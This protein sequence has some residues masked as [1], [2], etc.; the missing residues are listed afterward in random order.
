MVIQTRYTMEEFIEFVHLPGNEDRL[1]ELING[2]ITEAA[3]RGTRFSET[4]H[5]ITFAVRLFCRDHDILDGGDVLP[6]FSIAVA[7][8]FR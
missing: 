5:I 4:E 6:G 1:F 3:P 7:E 8:L 2:E